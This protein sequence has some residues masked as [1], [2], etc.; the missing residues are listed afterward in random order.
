MSIA[1]QVKRLQNVRNQIRTKMVALGLSKNTDLLQDLADD[2][3]GVNKISPTNN[4]TTD[5]GT[6]YTNVDTLSRSTSTRYI[7]VPKGYNDTDRKFTV[8]GVANGAYSASVSSHTTSNAAASSSV[9]G[10]VTDVTTTTKPSGTDGTDYYTITPKLSTTAGLSKATGKATIDAAG[11]LD[12]GNKSSSESSKSVEVTASQGSNRY[13]KAGAYSASVSSHTTTNATA[14]SSVNGSITSISSTAKPATGTDGV[15]YY[16]ITPGLVT[17]NG[18][19]KATG[20][21]T[22]GTAGYLATGDTTSTESSKTV[23]VTASQGDDYYLQSS[24][25]TKENPG[26]DP[27]ASYLNRAT[28]DSSTEDQ[29]VKITGGYLPDS[30]ITLK[31]MPE[32]SISSATIDDPGADYTNRTTVTPAKKRQY[33]KIDKGYLPNG[34]IT[35]EAI[36]S[37]SFDTSGVTATAD[38]VLKDYKFVDSNGIT[39][40][41]TI[42][43][44]TSNDVSGNVSGSNPEKIT[45]TTARTSGSSSTT[46]TAEATVAKKLYTGSSN[47]VKSLTSKTLTATAEATLATATTSSTTVP[48]TLP[49]GTVTITPSADNTKRIYS[50]TK[51]NGFITN[52]VLNPMPAGAYS[53]SVASHTTSNATASSNVSGSIVNVTS[54]TK[55]SGTDGSDYFTITPTLTTSAGSSKATGKATVDTAGYLVTGNATSSESS[56][57]VG[58]TASQGSNYYLKASSVTKENPGVDPGNRYGN[59]A[60]VNPS[61]VDQYVKITGGYLSDSKITIKKMTEGSVSSATT[62]DPG[63]ENQTT[64]T[65]SPDE[66]YVKISAGHLPHSKITVEAIPSPYFDTSGVTATAGT[67]LKDYKFVNS[68]GTTV[69]GTIATASSSNISGSVSGDNPEKITLTT[70]KTSGSSSTTATASA[71]VTKGLYTGSSNIEKDLTSQDFTATAEA[72]LAAS[73]MGV[74]SVPTTLPPGTVTI[75]PSTDNVKRIYSDSKN[76]GFITNVVLEAMPTGSYSPSVAFHDITNPT[77]SSSVTGSI[78]NIAS[79]TTPEGTDGTDYYTI[80]PELTTNAGSSKAKGKATISTAGYLSADSTTSPESSKSVEVEASPGK[81]Y[82]LKAS[83]VTKEKPGADPGTSYTNR[84]T[85]T[86]STS[87]QYVKV[88]AGYLSNSKIKVEAIPSPYFDTSGVTAAAS[89]VLS[90]KKFVNSSG[91]TITGTIATASSGD[92]SGSVSGSDPEKITLTTEETLKSSTTTATAEATVTKGLYTGSSNIVA[93]LTSKDFTATAEAK[94]ATSVS[95]STTVPST[96]PSGTVTIT[97]NTDNTKRIYSDSTNKG[98]ITNVVLKPMSTS[99]VTIPDPNKDP[100]TDYT[101]QVTVTPSGTSAKYVK[102]TAGHLPNSKITIEKMAG[103]SVADATTTKPDTSSTS[104]PNQTTVTPTKTTQYVK[105]TAGYLPNSK[106]TIDAIPSTTLTVAKN[107]WTKLTSATELGSYSQTVTGVTGV[108]TDNDVVVVPGDSSVVALYGVYA[109]SQ[110]ASSITFKAFDKPTSDMS[111]KVYIL[112]K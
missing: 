85:V 38:T 45:L 30:K 19:S 68:S 84:A 82:Y 25:V 18:G 107:A 83:S 3:D 33:V 97:P 31:K 78:T 50:D 99:S 75:T 55:P 73:V 64:V 27:G 74:K 23:E 37:S 6:G 63:T 108:L 2:L 100:G 54:A 28:V 4:G 35:V 110:G 101:N 42:A 91:T 36:S 88:T 13:L 22:I 76:K 58:V 14:S 34:K 56:K 80:T 109:S 44:A 60:T 67:V 15:D 16:T 21:A 47:I 66:Q 65:P 87:T 112:N 59:R 57:T 96:L 92:V 90:G 26:V 12:A 7:K 86:P 89:D 52:V 29:Y 11:Y 1:T 5:P 10:S 53:A 104:Y 43:T 106:I 70:E 51:N 69:T 9:T 81:D 48:S 49:T 102:I 41:G 39:V 95:G 103:G 77:A 111:Y 72:T 79:T 62:T 46:A 24:V 8:S 98:F 105:I 61:M 40:T 20:K 94:L 17:G 93:D 71:T 32:G